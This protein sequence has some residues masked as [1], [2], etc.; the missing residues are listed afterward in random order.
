MRKSLLIFKLLLISLLMIASINTSYAK[1]GS[2][3]D[4]CFQQDEMRLEEQSLLNAI[5]SDVRLLSISPSGKYAVSF[6][7]DGFTGELSIFDLE[8]MEIKP[9][10]ADYDGSAADEYGSMRKFVNHA[11]LQRG[12]RCAW[13]PD[14]QKIALY[15]Y[16][17]VYETL[18]YHVF[19]LYV[20]DVPAGKL[21]MLYGWGKSLLEGA[22][23]G[24]VNACFSANSEELFFSNAY[25]EILSFGSYHL[26]THKLSSRCYAALKPKELQQAEWDAYLD[27]LITQNKSDYIGN[28]VAKPDKISDADWEIFI[29]STRKYGRSSSYFPEA[30][31]ERTPAQ[32]YV[33]SLSIGGKNDVLQLYTA[34]NEYKEY[35]VPVKQAYAKKIQI[36][37]QTG[38]GIILYRTP[39]EEPAQHRE[40]TYYL[41]IFQPDRDMQGFDQIICL[42]GSQQCSTISLENAVKAQ[43]M[44][45]EICNATLS[46]DGKYALLLTRKM[47]EATQSPCFDLYVMELN[48]RQCRRIETPDTFV[49]EAQFYMVYGGT[50][51]SGRIFPDGMLWSGRNL[52]L[53]GRK[54][55]SFVR[56]AAE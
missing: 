2:I 43:N 13:S 27:Q 32:S 16:Q 12:I 7:D 50:G 6:E 54:L 8:K 20:I 53:L 22:V 47:L 10:T 3:W 25:S 29:N 35:T 18:S 14:E 23:G 26:K 34:Q 40:F 21:Q 5:S 44:Q 41:S 52:L 55:Y 11:F 46:P 51:T 56:P 33:R 31:L 19:N 37:P 28:D 39:L 42:N 45:T 4:Q 38:W 17:G 1:D 24:V 48:T 49:H 36:S 9:V 15:N 30:N